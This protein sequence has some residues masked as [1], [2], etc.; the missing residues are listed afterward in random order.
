MIL[1]RVIPADPIFFLRIIF[2]FPFIALFPNL[3]TPLALP[4]GE[5]APKATERAVCSLSQNQPSQYGTHP[6]PTVLRNRCE[7]KNP[8]CPLRR[9]R[10]TSPIGEAR[11][12]TNFKPLD[13]LRFDSH[14]GRKE[15]PHGLPC[16]V[17]GIML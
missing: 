6:L 13:K 9:I 2:K 17:V 16:G 4:L 5:L 8:Y 15:P 11:V 7:F 1:H 14:A 3:Y 12:C 10:D